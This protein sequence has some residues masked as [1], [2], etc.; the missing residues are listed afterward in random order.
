MHRLA[1]LLAAVVLATLVGAAFAGPTQANRQVPAGPLFV[2]TDMG[3]DDAVAVAYL[4]REPRAEVTGFTTVFGNASVDNVTRN[5]LTLLDAADEAYPVTI[6]AATPL[7]FPRHRTSAFVHGPDGFWFAQAPQDLSSLPTDAPA[8]IAAAAQANPGITFVALGP[9]TNFAQAVERFPEAM[10]GARLVALGGAQF[11]GNVTPVAEFNVYADPQA[12]AAVLASEMRVELI[13]LD[14]FEQIQI[15]ADRLAE[16]LSRRGGAV[17]QL[18]AAIL[19]LYAQATTQGAGGPITIPDLAAATYAVRASVGTPI[20]SL[21]RVITDPT[22][23]RGQTIIATTFS[24][25]ILLIGTS[26]ELSSL[27]DRAFT[28]GFDLNAELAAIAAREPD[29]AQA[30]LEI[31]ERQISRMLE[32][33]LLR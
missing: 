27:A 28:P 21:V 7:V 9:L 1:R 12:F 6:G 13:T 17:G 25:K 11:G 16:R 26:E 32:R 15:D 8:A 29:N 2:D 30:V 20:S 19:P 24:D 33:A 5:L 31:D 18:L 3:V 10:R 23:T 4:L 22:Y 14:A